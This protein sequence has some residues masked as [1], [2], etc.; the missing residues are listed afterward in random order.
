MKPYERLVAWERSHGLVL[1]VY[2]A[3]EKWPSAERF[4]LTGQLRRAA[5]SIPANIAEGVAKRGKAE[6]RRFL[7]IALG[8]LSEVCYLLRLARDLGL[9]NNAEWSAVESQRDSAGRATWLLYRSLRW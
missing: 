4:G 6:Y 8:S 1:A 9:L 3:T 2:R 5:V 7:D